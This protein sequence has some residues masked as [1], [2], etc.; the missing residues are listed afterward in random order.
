M[1]DKEIEQINDFIKYLSF[2]V[3]TLSG[4][5]G[6]LFDFRDK[7]TKRITQGGYIIF[8]VIILS[9]LLSIASEV[10]SEHLNKKEK[11]RQNLITQEQ[12]RKNDA[13]LKQVGTAVHGI[14][15][16]LNGTKKILVGVNSSSNN[17]QQ[18]LKKSDRILGGV[19]IATKGIATNLR[20]NDTLISGVGVAVN[21]I[22]RSL[23]PLK[24]ISLELSYGV[25]LKDQRFNPW[26]NGFK[27]FAKNHLDHLIPS[28]PILNPVGDE[29]LLLTREE[30]NS[31][32]E[33]SMLYR[34][35]I[36]VSNPAVLCFG[37]GHTKSDLYIRLRTDTPPIEQFK[38][39]LLNY[40]LTY[41]SKTE[42][43]YFRIFQTIKES[44]MN[45]SGALIS[46]LDLQNSRLL[47]E[48]NIANGSKL[49]LPDMFKTISL[50]MSVNG[51]TWVLDHFRQS[52]DNDNIY[53]DFV[54][55]TKIMNQYKLT[56]AEK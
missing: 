16:N 55:P 49:P 25:Q 28:N 17:I 27:E 30:V 13:I 40:P 22:N 34:L 32:A 42:T 14:A 1:T 9:G 39:Q 52:V 29:V 48:F 47:V 45:P 12:L 33:S 43:L 50:T 38:D 35:L 11:E 53:Y 6:L 44:E 7:R 51:K 3:A 31:L 20:K 26:T 21:D 56:S 19:H 10:V 46:V 4:I 18:T 36:D 5:V 23:Y 37:K 41:D 24:E 54:F 2:V 15:E 8:S